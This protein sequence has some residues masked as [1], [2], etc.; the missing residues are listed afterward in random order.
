MKVIIN[1]QIREI[2][3]EAN[4]E[5]A[6]TGLGVDPA[7]GGIALC[8]NGQVIP[9][10]AWGATLLSGQDQLEVVMATQGG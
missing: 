6:L 8:L 9:R 3:P 7:Q 5:Q 2:P 10:K 1:G 4:L